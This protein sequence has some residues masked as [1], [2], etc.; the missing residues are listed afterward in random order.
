MAWMVSEFFVMM[1]L[2]HVKDTLKLLGMLLLNQISA[3]LF[4]VN[5]D[6]RGFIMN[7]C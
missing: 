6:V 1:D 3:L 2:I 5:L 7:V 4:A